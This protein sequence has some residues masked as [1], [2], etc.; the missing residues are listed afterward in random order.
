MIAAIQNAHFAAAG[1]SGAP[2]SI[3][4]LPVQGATSPG[5]AASPFSDLMSDAIGNVNQLEDQ[6]HHAIEGLMSGSGVDIHEAMI[7]GEKASMAF[8]MVLAVRNKAI[9]SYQSIMNMQF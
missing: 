8:E 6:A 7:A 4:H 5:A 9:Q 1:L 2:Q 3:A